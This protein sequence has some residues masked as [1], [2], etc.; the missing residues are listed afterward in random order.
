MKIV[1]VVK[2]LTNDESYPFQTPTIDIKSYLSSGQHGND[3]AKIKAM[4]EKMRN[5]KKAGGPLNQVEEEAEEEEGEVRPKDLFSKYKSG[6]S[7]G[8]RYGGSGGYT[9]TEGPEDFTTT[10]HHHHNHNHKKWEPP[11]ILPL[12]L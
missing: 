6:K 11:G 1:F 3:P 2:C 10:S 12:N 9:S 5:K 8:S 4:L 7:K